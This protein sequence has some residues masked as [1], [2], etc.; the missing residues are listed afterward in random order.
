MLRTNPERCHYFLL[1]ERVQRWQ[2]KDC[3]QTQGTQGPQRALPREPKKD[4]RPCDCWLPHHHQ[5]AEYPVQYP[6]HYSAKNP[7]IWPETDQKVCKICALWLDR[8]THWAEEAN[9]WFLGKTGEG[10]ST[11]VPA[12]SYNGWIMDI[13]LWPWTQMPIKDL[14]EGWWAETT[15]ATQDPCN[16]QG[17]DCDFFWLPRYDLLRICATPPNSQPDLL[18]RNHDQIHSCIPQEEA[19]VFSSRA[20]LQTHGQRPGPQR[21][22]DPPT[23]A[24]ARVDQSPPTSLFPWSGPLWLLPVP[25]DQMPDQGTQVQQSAGTEGC[26]VR[27]GR[28]NYSW[29]VPPLYPPNLAQEVGQVSAVQQPVL[30]RDAMNCLF[31]GTFGCVCVLTVPG[32]LTPIVVVDIMLPIVQKQCKKECRLSTFNMFVFLSGQHWIEPRTSHKILLSLS[33]WT[34][35][36]WIEL[37]FL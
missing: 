28:G 4:W 36:N 1:D 29:W 27:P 34:V 12:C 15:E 13:Y 37:I 16:S 32:H 24:A 10:K 3:R 6:I 31:F 7:Q 8:E 17:H 19:K 23:C 22:I 26:G 18:Q 20:P 11:C 5:T 21:N 35:M 2:N 33:S 25:E 14:V 30:W 9:L